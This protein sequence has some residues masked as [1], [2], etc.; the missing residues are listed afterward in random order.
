MFSLNNK[1]GKRARVHATAQYSIQNS[2]MPKFKK[3]IRDRTRL[4]FERG[5]RETGWCWYYSVLTTDGDGQ[6]KKPNAGAAL[7]L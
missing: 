7:V 2:K 6:A 1:K 4:V 5:R 3:K